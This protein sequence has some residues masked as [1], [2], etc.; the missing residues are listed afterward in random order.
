MNVPLVVVLDPALT[1]H[2]P[3]QL[4]LSTG[5]RAI[6][7][8]VE[9]ICSIDAQPF[10]EASALHAIKLL[11]A[12]LRR[13]H[14]DANDFS[15]RL[16]CQIGM[17]LSTVGSQTGVRKGA[18]HAIGHVLG[19]AAG[20]PHGLTSCVMLPSVLRYNASVNAD[21]Q[22]LVSGALDAP[23]RAAGDLVEDLIKQ[24]GLPST[25]AGVGVRNER[26]EEIA[27]KAMDDPWTHSNPRKIHGPADILQILEMAAG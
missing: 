6:D 25:L 3:P 13:S 16:N 23:D 1:R 24:L 5:V 22:R 8:A 2:T 7:H 15:A 27:L 12:G 18:S 10:S 17:W 26:F 21:R 20:V 14:E 19:A 11:N 9:D 4:W